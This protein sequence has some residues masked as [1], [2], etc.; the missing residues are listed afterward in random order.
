MV[1]K[2]FTQVGRCESSG[3]GAVSSHGKSDGFPV[4]RTL[5]WTTSSDYS[6]R[7]PSTDD[8]VG[9]H[10]IFIRARRLPADLF[11]VKALH[12]SAPEQ[13]VS[14]LSILLIKKLLFL[15]RTFIVNFPQFSPRCSPSSWP[16]PCN[17]TNLP[18]QHFGCSSMNCELF[19][20]PSFSLCTTI[21]SLM[22]IDVDLFIHH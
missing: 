4:T 16:F 12:V 13:V 15:I 6:L 11:Q 19:L 8:D 2:D 18:P 10:W 17:F 20:F 21:G 3:N 9:T 5:L 22:L 14:C 7:S 1:D